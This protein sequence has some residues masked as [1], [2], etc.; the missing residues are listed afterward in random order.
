MAIYSAAHNHLEEA[1]LAAAE[2]L[3]VTIPSSY[4]KKGFDPG[5]V[6]ALSADV[7]DL[8]YLPMALTSSGAKLMGKHL[9]LDES[10][11]HRAELCAAFDGFLTDI[12]STS[13]GD[14]N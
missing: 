2:G 3:P 8:V 1:D 13:D 14:S 10:L 5:K 6:K 9:G 7:L 12:S 11:S 4:K